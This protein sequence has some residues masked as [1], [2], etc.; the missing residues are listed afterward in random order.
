MF[1]KVFPLVRS[2][3]DRKG[4]GAGFGAPGRG[5]GGPGGGF[6]NINNSS[7]LPLLLFLLKPPPGPPKPP[8][9]KKTDQ[10]SHDQVYHASDKIKV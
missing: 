7:G 1:P 4:P 9:P 2:G 3:E 10:I 5:F 6:L 8:P